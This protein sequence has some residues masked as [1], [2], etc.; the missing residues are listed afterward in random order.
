MESRKEEIENKNL[1]IYINIY[2]YIYIYI[3]NLKQ[4][5]IL[6]KT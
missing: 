4:I 2:I 1:P 6:I 3:K 5:I